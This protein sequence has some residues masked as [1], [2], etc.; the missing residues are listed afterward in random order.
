VGGDSGSSCT[1]R[2]S[3]QEFFNDSGAWSGQFHSLNTEEYLDLHDGDCPPPTHSQVL[4][5]LYHREPPSSTLEHPNEHI[6]SRWMWDITIFATSPGLGCPLEKRRVA[7]F[8]VSPLHS[9]A[10]LLLQSIT[11]LRF[12]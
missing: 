7:P 8:Q 10:K 4:L 3:I 2:L 6:C 5:S 9:T 1:L 11:V 12:R